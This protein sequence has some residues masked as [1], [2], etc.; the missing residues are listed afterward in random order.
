MG[1]V[2]DGPDFAYTLWV[3][4][5]RCAASLAGSCAASAPYVLSPAPEG[6]GGRRTPDLRRGFVLGCIDIT[7]TSKAL[8]EISKISML[9]NILQISV[10]NVSKT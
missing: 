7:A 1:S 9:I 2:L 4:E 5:R 3:T 10:L 6:K 8:A